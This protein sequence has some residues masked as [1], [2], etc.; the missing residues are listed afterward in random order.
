MRPRH[1]P[2][3]WLMTDE[4]MGDRLWDAL[5][6]LPRGSGIVFRHHATAAAERR[7]LFK[8]VARI[9]RQRRLVPVRAGNVPMRGEQGVH[10][11][12]RRGAGVKT[13]AVHD[14]REAIAAWRARADLVFV[15][16]VFA[17]RSHPR[18]RVLGV[19][20]LGLLLRTSR[21]PAVAL[22]GVDAKRF[23]RLRGLGLH[24]W[25]GIDAWTRADAAKPPFNCLLRQTLR[26]G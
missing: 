19:A 10:N 8:Q 9:A 14:R 22:G 7:R 20:R 13:F 5:S 11:A 18:A 25:A 24:G 6:R 26:T 1:L 16:P 2:K 17:T 15:S 3:L 21:V 4:R 23:R 12:V